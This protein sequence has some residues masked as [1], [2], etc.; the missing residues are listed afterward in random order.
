MSAIR[1][2]RPADLPAILEIYAREVATG[3]ASFELEPPDLAEMSRRYEA[4][5][6]RE[7]P[8]LVA[9]DDGRLAGYGY[10][11]PYHL[12]PGYRW[13][14][15]D[16]VYV[17]AWAR[18]SGVGRALLEGVIERAAAAGMRQMLAIISQSATA[19]AST[20]LHERAGF[21]RVGTLEVVGFK[22]GRWLDVAILQ[23]PLGPGPTRSPGSI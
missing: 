16:S 1:P 9:E 8:Y 21:R 10:A 14:V 4:V 23:R 6:A 5:T 22:H 19:D 12:R 11:S 2:A 15:E 13:T 7:L 17:A 18:R 3:T 20:R